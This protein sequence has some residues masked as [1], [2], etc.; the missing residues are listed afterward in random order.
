MSNQLLHH[1]WHDKKFFPLQAKKR[2]DDL[3]KGIIDNFKRKETPVVIAVSRI[4]A[5]ALIVPM[6]I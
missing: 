4:K 3:K 2:K 1:R 5:L 6:K